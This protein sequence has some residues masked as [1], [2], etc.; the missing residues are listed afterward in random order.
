MTYRSLREYERR[1]KAALILELLKESKCD[2]NR[3][4]EIVKKRIEEIK[5]SIKRL[6]KMSREEFLSRIGLFGVASKEYY[7]SKGEENI[8]RLERALETARYLI[9][10]WKEGGKEWEYAKYWYKKELAGYWR[11]IQSVLREHLG[12]PGI[13]KY[14][15][16]IDF[17][18]ISPL[19]ALGLFALAKGGK[20]ARTAK[21]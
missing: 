13:A 19:I 21:R 9:K 20:G 16:I 14:G 7:I 3:L 8:N 2:T 1:R 4:E 5:E 12:R 6:R 18:M 11:E 17:L 10:A 15:R